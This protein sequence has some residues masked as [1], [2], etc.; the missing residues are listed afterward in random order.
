MMPVHQRIIEA[1]AQAFGPRRFD[2]FAD[3][4][5]LGTELDGIV[6]GELGVPVAEAFMMLGG[7]HHV[8]H[9][10]RLGELGPFAR[11]CPARD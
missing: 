5:A 1:D 9:A 3:H 6:V 8:F 10:R 11:A 2:I 4:I 7:Q